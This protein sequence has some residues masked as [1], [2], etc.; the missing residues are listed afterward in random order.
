M[1]NL[2]SP[3]FSKA[4]LM[5][6][7]R[8]K[9]SLLTLVALTVLA[10]CGVQVQEAAT[11]QLKNTTETWR[12][13]GQL[14]YRLALLEGS[15]PEEKVAVRLSRVADEDH[16]FGEVSVAGVIYW[17]HFRVVGINRRWDFGEEFKHA[18]VIE[19]NGSGA[20]YEF[21]NVEDGGKTKPSQHFNCVSP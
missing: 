12:C 2:L 21:S 6:E 19:P 14:D 7:K 3:E 9:N 16:E 8:M 20:Y 1:P 13:F 17:A 10:A 11:S 4:F 15:F 18:F 5:K